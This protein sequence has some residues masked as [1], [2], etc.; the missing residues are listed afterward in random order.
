MRAGLL[1]VGTETL[2]LVILA[3][4]APLLFH[5]GLSTSED[6]SLVYQWAE[7][8]F[9]TLLSVLLET[10]ALRYVL[11]QR[12]LMKHEARKSTKIVAVACGWALCHLMCTQIL[13]AVTR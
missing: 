9:N 7:I 11:S 8:T 1:N 12:H 5:S 13:K 3:L 2:K 4:L 10:Y 6:T